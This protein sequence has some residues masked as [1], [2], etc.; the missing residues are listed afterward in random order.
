MT[1][2]HQTAADRPRQPPAAAA[3]SP[4]RPAPAHWAHDLD[5]PLPATLSQDARNAPVNDLSSQ[6]NARLSQLT[7]QGLFGAAPPFTADD[8]FVPKDDL[9]DPHDTA[10]PT[11]KTYPDLP[12]F[13]VRNPSTQVP[14]MTPSAQNEPQTPK[15][16]GTAGDSLR[17]SATAPIAIR[18]G[19]LRSTFSAETIPGSLSPGSALSSPALNALVD[20]TPLPSPLVISESPAAFLRGAAFRPRSRGASGSSRDD[21]F[22][23]FG[24]RNTLSPSPSLKKKGYE[25]L[26]MAT[27]HAAEQREEADQRKRSLSE[28][29]P[30]TAHNTGSRHVSI[31]NIAPQIQTESSNEPQLHREKYLAAKRGLVPAATA[32]LPTPPASSRSVTESE[33][34]DVTDKSNY[35]TIRQGPQMAKKPWRLIRLL[36]QGTFSKVWLATSEKVEAKDPVD[37]A[38]LDYRKL[39]AVKVSEHGPAGGADSERIAISL[40]R[41]VEM[42]RSV[43]HPSLVR[44]RAFEDGETQAMLVLTY[45]PGGDLFDIA[46]SNRDVLSVDLVQR[47]FAELVSATRYLHDNLVVHRDIKLESTTFYPMQSLHPEQ[48]LTNASQ[49]SSSTFPSQLYPF[50][51]VRNHIRT[52]S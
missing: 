49:M 41:E 36:G 25:R 12:R 23:F 9:N 24:G 48:P 45:C 43:S 13:H 20:L 19:Y 4:P 18:D 1:S 11:L 31:S 46:S 52:P 16:D 35:I 3:S 37:E 29:R 8:L 6:L 14:L 40:K 32:G 50:S 42:L 34:E 17:H 26:K 21:S 30:D 28:F 5:A 2:H 22:L 39:V 38:T 7:S 33:E 47:I 15:V 10:D 51:S 44:M 27:T